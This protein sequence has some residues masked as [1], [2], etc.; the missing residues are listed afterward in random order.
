[1]CGDK[2]RIVENE[3]K[4]AIH[5]LE[6]LYENR[7]ELY[8]AHEYWQSLYY[9]SRLDLKIEKEYKRAHADLNRVES[10]LEEHA[11]YCDEKGFIKPMLNYDLS[12]MAHHEMR[13]NFKRAEEKYYR[14]ELELNSAQNLYDAHKKLCVLAGVITNGDLY[15]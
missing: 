15:G 11:H 14:A 1:M 9:Q 2:K 6:L 8:R 3:L 10:L 7:E 4:E 5:K 13:E 12:V